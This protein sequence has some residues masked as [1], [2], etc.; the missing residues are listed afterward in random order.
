M[1]KRVFYTELSY[2]F[3]LIIMSFGAA[4]T[5]KASFGDLRGVGV[6]TICA[7]LNGFLISRFSKLLE[8]FFDFKNK[9]KIQKCFE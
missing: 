8:K 4:F 5:E 3:G 7:L 6:G 2:V 9:F 1:K